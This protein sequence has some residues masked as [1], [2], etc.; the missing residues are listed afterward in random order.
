[1]RVDAFVEGPMLWAAFIIFIACVFLRITFFLVTVLKAGNQQNGIASEPLTVIFRSLVPFHM[2]LLRKP[3]YAVLRYVFHLCLFVVPIWLTGH[4]M[5]WSESRFGWE[6]IS[7]PDP[8][9]DWMTIILLC[10]AGYFFLRRLLVKEIRQ[11]SSTSD[12]FLLFVTSI[13][14]LSGYFVTHGTLDGLGFLGNHIRTIHVLSA[15]LMLVVVAFLFCRTRLDSEKC[16]GC[17]TCESVCPTGTLDYAD[18][19]KIRNFYYRTSQ[20]ISCGACVKV[21]P[22]AAA[23]LAHEIRFYNIFMPFSKEKIRS[24][25]LAVCKGCGILFAP[26]PLLNRIDRDIADD[27]RRYCSKCKKTQLAANFYT[28]ASLQNQGKDEEVARSTTPE[29]T[30]A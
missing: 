27:Y 30:L 28:P 5:L 11:Q 23:D 8:W 19:G 18:E 15:E 2:G 16:T 13:P 17:A 29:S 4:I 1:M 22:E 21:C 20:C 7:L 24:V 14:F 9:A 12:F 3:I 10:I 26:E 6:W 25:E